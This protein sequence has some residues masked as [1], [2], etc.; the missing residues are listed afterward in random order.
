MINSEGRL[1]QCSYVNHNKLRDKSLW[2]YSYSKAAWHKHLY[3]NKSIIK[4]NLNLSCSSVRVGR[5]DAAMMSIINLWYESLINPSISK[6]HDVRTM[7]V[8]A[9]KNR[10]KSWFLHWKQTNA[11]PIHSLILQLLRF[12]SCLR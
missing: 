9:R 4:S 11:W 8:E 2:V 5:I 12:D 10:L 7:Y 3:I 1:D 6:D